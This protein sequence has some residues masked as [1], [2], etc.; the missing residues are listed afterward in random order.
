MAKLFGNNLKQPP[1]KPQVTT[2][3]RPKAAPAAPPLP[4]AAP[5]TAPAWETTAQAIKAP[6]S[7]PVYDVHEIKAP[8]S[9]PTYEV[10]RPSW[11]SAD[12]FKK[13]QDQ[14][15]RNEAATL[16]FNELFVGSGHDTGNFAITYEK[17]AQNSFGYDL[18]N[19]DVMRTDSVGQ[20]L[21]LIKGLYETK[22]R[23][24]TDRHEAA[25]LDVIQTYD[26]SYSG[27][28]REEEDDLTIEDVETAIV[29]ATTAAAEAKQ[30]F[31][32]T[33]QPYMIMLHDLLFPHTY[34]EDPDSPTYG[35]EIER[36]WDW[37]KDDDGNIIYD[38]VTGMA[39]IVPLRALEVERP[40]YSPMSTGLEDLLAQAKEGPDTQGALRHAAQILGYQDIG[41]PDDADYQS[42]EDQY[43][44]YLRTART[45][46]TDAATEAAAKQ[47][48]FPSVED[49]NSW[50]DAQR[51]LK[52][53]DFE[54]YT[55]EEVEDLRRLSRSDEAAMRQ[56]AT[57][58]V[59]T[60][61]ANQ[62][63]FMRAMEVADEAALQIS[64][65]RLKS[66][67]DI[68]NQDI[69][70]QMKELETQR[71]AYLPTLQAAQAFSADYLTGQ[72]AAY[73]DTLRSG[74]QAVNDFISAQNEQMSQMVSIYMQQANILSQ[75]YENEVHHVQFQAENIMNAARAALGVES[76]AL[77]MY[78]QTYQ[79]LMG[80]L[81]DGWNMELAFDARDQ[82]EVQSQND[83]I[84]D[85]IGWGVTLITAFINPAAAAAMAG[86]KL[87][88]KTVGGPSDLSRTYR[89]V[90]SDALV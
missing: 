68:M 37:V 42:A 73:A 16:L 17:L 38:P 45:P 85:I 88:G 49:Y 89:S 30:R 83:T 57:S 20:K 72:R 2:W 67:I 86:A 15:W 47:L 58:A 28:V 60:M 3:E 11:M 52:R 14:Q 41:N 19:P 40:D 43:A 54:G 32:E 23:T 13:T 44:E 36:G 12:N 39:T 59:E 10:T 50:L 76:E 33:A 87:V 84:M 66:E 82:A 18:N 79:S 5:A 46:D 61:Y 21:D 34:D 4:G 8:P 90:P 22:Y 62:G 56:Q 9:A 25:I 53:T 27:V 35:E 80:P 71:E 64:N 6:P 24:G 65:F 51:N 48:G 69:A 74:T 77:N 29:D 81:M 55:D 26:P 75:E 70:L 7:A 78:T 31:L 1:G 63:S